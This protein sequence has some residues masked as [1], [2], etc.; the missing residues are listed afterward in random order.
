MRLSNRRGEKRKIEG[1][2]FLQ[3]NMGRVR[4][5]TA[6]RRNRTYM[7]GEL[8]VMVLMHEDDLSAR[9]IAERIVPVAHQYRFNNSTLGWILTRTHGII[10]TKSSPTSIGTYSVEPGRNPDLPQKTRQRLAA[11]LEKFNPPTGD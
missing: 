10:K 8:S 5:P 3:K 7:I 11:H 4:G 6:F 1:A 2:V 9:Q